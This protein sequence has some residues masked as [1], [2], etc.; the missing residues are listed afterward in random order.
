M[1]DIFNTEMNKVNKVWQDYPW[2][3]KYIY[4]SFLAQ[5]YYYV[6]HSCRLLA[7]AAALSKLSENNYFNRSIKHI[8]EESNHEVLAEKDLQRLGFNLSDFLETGTTRALYESQYY[9]IQNQ[10]PTALL[11]YILALEGIAVHSVPPVFSR[12]SQAFD[13]KSLNFLRVHSEEDPEHLHKAFEQIEKLNS[14]QKT[15]VEMNFLQTCDMY[16]HFLQSCKLVALS[17]ESTH[18]EKQAS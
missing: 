7:F 15:Y 3:N 12:L 10:D 9:K 5:T 2:E 6:S 8:S 11:G 1:K 16:T 13:K 4:G 17:S 18:L 14:E